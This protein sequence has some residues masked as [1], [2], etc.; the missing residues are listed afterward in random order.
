MSICI[1]SFKSSMQS[2]E[3]D[4]QCSV[5]FILVPRGHSPF[6]QHQKLRPLTGPIL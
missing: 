1:V 3:V 4:I 6:G 2:D 5:D